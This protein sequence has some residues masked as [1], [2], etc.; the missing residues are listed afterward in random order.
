[1]NVWAEPDPALPCCSAQWKSSKETHAVKKTF[2][3]LLLG[4][5]VV[6]WVLPALIAFS[7]A[8][9]AQKSG[10][11]AGVIIAGE[12]CFALAALLLGKDLWARLNPKQY[13]RR[14]YPAG[15]KRGTAPTPDAEP[16]DAVPP[17]P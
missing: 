3:Y 14:W 10:M 5:S 11:L 6:A 1:M 15:R 7:G 9:L 13:V 17:V 2:G 12:V 16:P 8:G 4:L